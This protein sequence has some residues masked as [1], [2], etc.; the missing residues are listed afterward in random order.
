MRE[1][2]FSWPLP[3]GEASIQKTVF[4]E[5]SH[6]FNARILVRNIRQYWIAEGFAGIEVEAR[7]DVEHPNAPYRIVSN[8]RTSG[9]PPGGR[10]Q[11][12]ENLRNPTWKL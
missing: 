12:I 5:Y 11:P 4:P 8:I 3:A 10:D 9:F 7:R 2:G 6:E 1:A